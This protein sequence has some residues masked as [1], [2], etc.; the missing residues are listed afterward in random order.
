MVL[1]SAP[2]RIKKIAYKKT[3]NQHGCKQKP[4]IPKSL[5]EKKLE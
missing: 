5:T 2:S 3:K 4:A 1:G